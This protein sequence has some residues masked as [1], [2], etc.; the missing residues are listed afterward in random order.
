MR[1]LET[2]KLTKTHT[3]V[4]GVFYQTLVAGRYSVE[5]PEEYDPKLVTADDMMNDPYLRIIGGPHE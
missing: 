3:N 4:D 2:V 5:M 1:K